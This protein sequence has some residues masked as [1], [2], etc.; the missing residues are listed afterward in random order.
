[1]PS[2]RATAM[3][4]SPLAQPRTMRDRNAN[5]CAV[6]RRAVQRSSVA[7]SSALTL[8]SVFGRPVI[9]IPR[10]QLMSP[11]VCYIESLGR[12]TSGLVRR[13][14]RSGRQASSG[15]E[16]PY[17]VLG[18]VVWLQGYEA[19]GAAFGNVQ[20]LAGLGAQLS[21]DP[22]AEGWRSATQVQ[23]H[24]VD[25]PAVADELRGVG[26]RSPSRGTARRT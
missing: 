21:G 10:L 26:V 24:V 7:R 12:D 6:V 19:V 3:L 22:L 5:P 25:R 4:D 16:L 2:L 18:A 23:G 20:H 1:M 11:D 14:Y 17:Q 13:S 9:H 8:S 15:V